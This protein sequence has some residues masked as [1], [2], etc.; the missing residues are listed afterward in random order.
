[1]QMVINTRKAL[2]V[3]RLYF[4][5]I[6][7]VL[8]CA[9][10]Y[11]MMVAEPYQKANRIHYFKV[12]E[13]LE[14][15]VFGHHEI[16]A[17]WLWLRAI[18]D[19]DICEK[20]KDVNL[21]KGESWLFRMLRKITDLSPYSRQVYAV[22]AVSLSVLTGD[23]VGARFLFDKGIE[24]FPKDW[25][26]LYRAAY[27]YLYEDF[28]PE[29]AADLL[30]KTAASGGPPWT[31]KLADRVENPETRREIAELL[32]KDLEA[33]QVPAEVIKKIREKLNLQ[34]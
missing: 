32:I 33:S 13:K 25:P 17:D 30:R 2:L 7:L 1:M 24:Y 14:H 19:M 18:Q 9:S 4:F 11:S 31:A 8:I 26:I 6:T 34:H 16:V 5:L 29:L 28:E 10:H 20:N 27:F 22:G 21:C 12:P 15:F 23:Q 3:A